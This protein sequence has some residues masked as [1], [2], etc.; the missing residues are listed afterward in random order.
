[1]AKK[2]LI[3]YWVKLIKRGDKVETEIPGDIH[4]EV[5][6]KINEDGI[7]QK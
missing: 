1:M 2:A 5:M 4:D 3:N 6:K 7:S